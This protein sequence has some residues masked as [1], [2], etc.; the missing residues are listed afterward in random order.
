MCYG[1][2]CVWTAQLEWELELELEW[3]L[4]D[5]EVEVCVMLMWWHETL[6]GFGVGVGVSWVRA[7][8]MVV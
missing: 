5:L 7:W 6:G 8:E 4:A 3:E 1:V 2:S